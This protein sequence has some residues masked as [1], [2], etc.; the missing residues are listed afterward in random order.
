MQVHENEPRVPRSGEATGDSGELRC[1]SMGGAWG[2]PAKR[3]RGG[4]IQRGDAGGLGSGVTLLP[5]D[6][7]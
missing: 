7:R 5:V 4:Q 3:A 1:G 2:T 6:R